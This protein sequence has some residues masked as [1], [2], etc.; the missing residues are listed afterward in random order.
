MVE[1]MFYDAVGTEIDVKYEDNE[2]RKSVES[3]E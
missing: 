1:T 2:E 3:D